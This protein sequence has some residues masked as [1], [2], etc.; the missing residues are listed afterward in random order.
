MVSWDSFQ[1]LY[2]HWS[3][4]QPQHTG[5]RL[6]LFGICVC[7]NAR[8]FLC[9]GFFSLHV[10]Y[11]VHQVGEVQFFLESSVQDGEPK[12]TPWTP[13]YPRLLEAGAGFSH[14]P[15][16]FWEGRFIGGKAAGLVWDSRLRHRGQASG[17]LVCGPVHSGPVSR[18]HPVVLHLGVPQSPHGRVPCLLAPGGLGGGRAGEDGVA[19]GWR[20]PSSEWCLDSGELRS[21]G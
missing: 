12:G 3:R 1:T 9:F 13:S 2:R 8:F 21:G 15:K 17:K 16:L 19:Y 20:G 10:V 5:A 11:E 6:G 7:L 14:S 4:G 18:Q